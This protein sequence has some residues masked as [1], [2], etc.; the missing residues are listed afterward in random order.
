[1]AGR[2][3]KLTREALQARGPRLVLGGFTHDDDSESKVIWR[4][5]ESCFSDGVD[6]ASFMRQLPN[7]H[8]LSGRAIARS[9]S[10]SYL[11]RVGKFN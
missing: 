8:Y 5:R 4:E 9:F 7:G 1:M 6:E 10:L 2:T 11:L 3:G